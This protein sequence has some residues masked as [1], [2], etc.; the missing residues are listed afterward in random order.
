MISLISSAWSSAGL[1]L[2][3]LKVGPSLLSSQDLLWFLLFC[4]SACGGSPH[5]VDLCTF[6]VAAFL[7]HVLGVVVPEAL[8][9]VGRH[10]NVGAVRF[11]LCVGAATGKVPS[12][13]TLILSAGVGPP[14]SVISEFPRSLLPG[15]RGC[16][17]AS[18][19]LPSSGSFHSG[20]L[21]PSLGFIRRQ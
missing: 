12:G 15:C 19:A 2:W 13:L 1:G 10:I 16:S 7:G 9:Y 14:L 8:K 20:V 5:Y 6:F 3:S 21:L 4:L 17:W 18:S 11:C